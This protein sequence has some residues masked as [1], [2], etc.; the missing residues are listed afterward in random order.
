M[1][2]NNT[3]SPVLPSLPAHSCDLSPKKEEKEKEGKEEEGVEE[4]EEEEEKE[5]EENEELV[6]VQ[7]VLPI[8]SHWPTP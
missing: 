4:E 7:F 3:H 8:Y 1:H 2:P 6:Q 5:E